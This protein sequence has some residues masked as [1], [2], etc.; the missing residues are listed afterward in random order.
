M[1]E[2]GRLLGQR[3]CSLIHGCVYHRGKRVKD[4]GKESK[5]KKKKKEKNEGEKKKGSVKRRSKDGPRG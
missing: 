4:A 2:N 3:P 1:L 5:G